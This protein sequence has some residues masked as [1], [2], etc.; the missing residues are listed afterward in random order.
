M[1]PFIKFCFPILLL[2]NCCFC[3]VST[4]TLSINKSSD[5]SQSVVNRKRLFNYED[6]FL[7]K[8]AYDVK[9]SPDGKWIV[10]VMSTGSLM[11]DNKKATI[12]LINTETGV[13]ERFYDDEATNP[14]WSPDTPM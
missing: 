6:I 7:L 11:S 14:L 8:R 9:I 12:W 13:S 10:Y 4:P 2:S 1:S 5:L 3:Q